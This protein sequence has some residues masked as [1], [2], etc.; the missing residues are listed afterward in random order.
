MN[1]EYRIVLLSL[2]TKLVI[3]I[4]K[5]YYEEQTGLIDSLLK[6][7]EVSVRPAVTANDTIVVKLYPEIIRIEGIDESK[8]T[9]STSISL[10][11]SWNDPRLSWPPD[12]YGG[13]QKVHL[14]LKRIWIPDIK[15]Y[16]LAPETVRNMVDDTYPVIV[17]HTGE[18]MYIPFTTLNSYCAL[19]LANFPYD[20]Q[21]C[22]IVLGSWAF[23]AQEVKMQ[24]MGQE[25]SASMD[26]PLAS[27]SGDDTP[28]EHPTWSLV[29]KKAEAVLKETKYDCC[30]EPY[31]SMTI[32]LKLQRARQFFK[33]MLV[34]PGVILSLLVPLQFLLPPSS[35]QRS[36][37]GM[38]IILSTTILVTGLARYFPY[39]HSSVPKIGIF[40]ITSMALAAAALVI[41][42]VIA[43][44]ANKGK[45]RRAMPAWL[46]QLCLASKCLR[47]VL[48]IAGTSPVNSMYSSVNSRLLDEM[49]EPA[50]EMMSGDELEPTSDKKE[51]Q[52]NSSEAHLR[53][54]A[55]SA[56]ISASKYVAEESL[57]RL[58]S[59]WQDLAQVL[60]RFCFVIF[61][62]LYI[63]II[64]SLVSNS[65]KVT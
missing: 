35:A 24:F 19:N 14:S 56:K 60:D 55:K 58:N 37:F 21:Q 31:Q 41:S 23:H 18:V 34:G 2:L 20:I 10:T 53:S 3:A 48:C 30:P 29:D 62:I 9:L 6:D 46:S 39:E 51:M 63:I 7:Y 64:L 38:L 8:D 28:S 49:Q 54:I 5:T 1:R 61:M 59:E 4:N 11:Q 22:N 36:L 25:A 33:Y 65:D 13:V 43:G 44:I 12:H 26:V 32:K 50:I 15:L 40:F 45:N 16:N 17:Q 42:T 47:R 57:E 27:Y 52:S